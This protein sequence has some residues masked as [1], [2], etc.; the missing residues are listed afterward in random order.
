MAL[1]LRRCVSCQLHLLDA[2]GHSDTVLE[3]IL[4]GKTQD[5]VF[6]FLDSIFM[7]RGCVVD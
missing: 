2:V 5:T 1:R 3:T 7:A 4:G 6:A